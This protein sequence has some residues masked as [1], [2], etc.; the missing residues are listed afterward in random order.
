MKRCWTATIKRFLFY[1]WVEYRGSSNLVHWVSYFFQFIAKPHGT[2]TLAPLNIS[3]LALVIVS[4][5][6]SPQNAQVGFHVHICSIKL[7]DKQGN[8]Y[9][10]ERDINFSPILHL[11]LATTYFSLLRFSRDTPVEISKIKKKKERSSIT[12]III[13]K[14]LFWKEDSLYYSLSP[15]HFINMSIKSVSNWRPVLCMNYSAWA[16]Y[17]NSKLFSVSLKLYSFIDM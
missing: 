15:Q 8:V 14:N 6:F 5:L 3:A 2:M 4:T 9:S 16:A 10:T 12:W 17:C 13:I 11:Y 7:N 1:L